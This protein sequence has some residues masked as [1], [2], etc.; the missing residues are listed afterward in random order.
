ME[1]TSTTHS[2]YSISK[3]PS[4]HVWETSFIA[5]IH[6]FMLELFPQNKSWSY[7]ST[8]YHFVD[9]IVECEPQ[10]EKLMLVISLSKVLLVAMVVVHDNVSQLHLMLIIKLLFCLQ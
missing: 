1:H 3:Q 9:V 5:K 10:T 4:Y 2:P 7:M 6:D 8:V